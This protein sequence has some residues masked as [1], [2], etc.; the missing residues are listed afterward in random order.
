MVLSLLHLVLLIHRQQVRTL[1]HLFC[2]I[3]PALVPITGA[4]HIRRSRSTGSLRAHPDGWQLAVAVDALVIL[5]ESGAAVGLVGLLLQLLLLAAP[6]RPLPQ[7]C[8]N[9][10]RNA[11]IGHIIAALHVLALLLQDWLDLLQIWLVLHS[12]INY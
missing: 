12:N 8:L 9:P 4:I 5:E 11:T 1:H 2:K 10:R 7:M 3:L 6:L